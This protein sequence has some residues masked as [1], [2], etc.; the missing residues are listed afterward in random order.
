MNCKG[1]FSSFF[2]FYKMTKWE[3]WE[4]TKEQAQDRE[5]RLKTE[6]DRLNEYLHKKIIGELTDETDELTILYKSNS[7]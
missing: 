5:D 7:Q 2:I 3:H 4:R 6:E 1:T